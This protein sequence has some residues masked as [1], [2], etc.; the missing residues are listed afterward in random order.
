MIAYWQ[1]FLNKPPARSERGR[2][3]GPQ[4]T[5]IHSNFETLWADIP[6]GSW[7]GCV[8]EGVPWL[9]WSSA[10][11]RG[12]LIQCFPWLLALLSRFSSF[13]II[14]LGRIWNGCWGIFFRNDTAFSVH[15][16]PTESQRSQDCLKNQAPWS[17]GSSTLL[18]QEVSYLLDS[19]Q[20]QVLVN[21]HRSWDTVLRTAIS[22][23][24][25]LFPPLN[26]RYSEPCRLWKRY[27]LMFFTLSHFIQLKYWPPQLTWEGL[28]SRECGIA[29]L[30]CSH[31]D[32]MHGTSTHVTGQS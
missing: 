27:T 21:I 13:P 15:P 10:L 6:R 7:S 32:V 4:Q 19:V 14:F 20:L 11:W 18:K 3:G 16:F 12:F 31:F 5:L 23:A 2:K 25:G 26:G 22:F 1:G 24:P 9:G 17:F 8:W 28:R 30:K 29:A